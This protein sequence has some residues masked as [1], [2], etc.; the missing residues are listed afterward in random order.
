MSFLLDFSDCSFAC[1]SGHNFAQLLLSDCVVRV[2]NQILPNFSQCEGDSG[3]ALGR[4]PDGRD[5]D[6]QVV[7]EVR[8]FGIGCL[9]QFLLLKLLI[10]IFP[11]SF[12]KR[13][14]ATHSLPVF[15]GAAS[16][17]CHLAQRLLLQPSHRISTR[18]EQLSHEI[19]LRMLLDRHNDF[20][21]DPDLLLA[22][23]VNVPVVAERFPTRLCILDFCFPRRKQQENIVKSK[24]DNLEK[25]FGEI[26]AGLRSNTLIE[27]SG[28]M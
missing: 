19:K 14:R 26:L 27:E 18:T 5:F 13:F 16:Q 17:D 1:F 24:I 22:V 10:L 15:H 6:V 23:D 3:V 7:V 20:H 4:R 12:H 25:S 2:W 28:S 9:S 8:I 11:V 21:D